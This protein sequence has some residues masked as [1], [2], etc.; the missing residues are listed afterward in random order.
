PGRPSG[1]VARRMAPNSA[2]S[3]PL[4]TARGAAG[5][6]VVVRVIEA[7]PLRGRP[8]GGGRLE[9]TDGRGRRGAA[10]GPGRPRGGG[11]GGTGGG[12][13]GG[14]DCRLLRKGHR[15]PLARR[16]EP[17]VNLRPLAGTDRDLLRE[18]DDGLVAPDDFGPEGVVVGRPVREGRADERAH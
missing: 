4:A 14:A 16:G 9:G 12:V 3:Y 10:G 5:G 8:C 7:W 2:L 17:E 11:G 6:R 15:L 18:G 13:G 1:P